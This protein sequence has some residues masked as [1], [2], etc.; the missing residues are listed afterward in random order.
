MFLFYLL[1]TFRTKYKKIIAKYFDTYAAAAIAA[2]LLL[3]I[4]A[5][6]CVVDIV[7]VVAGPAVAHIP[8]SWITYKSIC[9]VSVKRK[10]MDRCLG[11]CVF[12]YLDSFSL[13]LAV[14]YFKGFFHLQ[15]TSDFVLY[16]CYSKYQTYIIYS[17]TIMYEY[18]MNK[19]KQNIYR[20]HT[21]TNAIQNTFH[22]SI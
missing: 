2:P 7:T 20:A 17:C 18:C 14:I 8:L 1:H 11:V 13:L 5:P 21:Q 10:W 19:K 15:A 9:T 16:V 22:S 12:F 6:Y 4:T 3:R